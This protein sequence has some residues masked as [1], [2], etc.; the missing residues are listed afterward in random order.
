MYRCHRIY[1]HLVRTQLQ[2]TPS[3]WLNPQFLSSWSVWNAWFIRFAHITPRNRQSCKFMNLQIN[4][5]EENRKIKNLLTYWLLILSLFL[6][7]TFTVSALTDFMSDLRKREVIVL[8]WYGGV[9]VRD[10][11]SYHCNELSVTHTWMC[12]YRTT[13]PA[14][15]H[16]A[17][18]IVYHYY[19]LLTYRLWEMLPSRNVPPYCG[20]DIDPS[21]SDAHVHGKPHTSTPPSAATGDTWDDA[22]CVTAD[23]QSFS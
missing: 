4:W 8:T 2:T 19:C 18:I 16:V 9:I 1:H 21:A 5:K 20:S 3:V 23:A 7:L 6:W 11:Y 13:A 12:P 15:K 22:P 10:L 14:S 17:I